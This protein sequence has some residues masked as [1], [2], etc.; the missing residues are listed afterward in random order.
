MS[1]TVAEIKQWILDGGLTDELVVSLDG[2]GTL[3]ADIPGKVA[4]TYLHIGFVG[5][6]E[7]GPVTLPD[8]VEAL[9]AMRNAFTS[10]GTTCQNDAVRAADKVISKLSDAEGGKG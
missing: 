4:I 1:V 2:D 6:G 3:V 9:L 10:D 8:A 7:D 5:E